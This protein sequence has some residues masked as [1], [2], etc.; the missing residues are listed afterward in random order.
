MVVL[1][2]CGVCGEWCVGVCSHAV[3][4]CAVRDVG[5]GILRLFAPLHI[6]LHIVR[7]PGGGSGE[8]SWNVP[9]FTVCSP[10]VHCLSPLASLPPLH[11]LVYIFRRL[12]H[13]SLTSL[14]SPSLTSP[15]LSPHLPRHLST[16]LSMIRRH[17]NRTRE[18]DRLTSWATI[19][20]SKAPYEQV[21][22][23]HIRTAALQA[24]R[25]ARIYY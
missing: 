20:C 7:R 12:S 5:R 18:A 19:D 6:S 22:M 23:E 25:E 9:P 21:G 17:R 13:V 2:S 14:T 16:S 24:C 4:V 15:S 1:Y 8:V 11:D 10:S 3:S